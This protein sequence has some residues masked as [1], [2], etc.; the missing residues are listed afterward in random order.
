[1]MMMMMMM[2]TTT[3]TTMMLKVTLPTGPDSRHCKVAKPSIRHDPE[4]VPCSSLPYKPKSVSTEFFRLIFDLP[5][6]HVPEASQGPVIPAP[7][8]ACP[9]FNPLSVFTSKHKHLQDI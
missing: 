4:P 3:T 8:E 2:T 6:D 9:H 5:F 1:M 7:N